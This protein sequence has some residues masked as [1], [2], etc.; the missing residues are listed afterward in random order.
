MPRANPASLHA[1]VRELLRPYMLAGV[2]RVHFAGED[3]P[4]DDG[5]ATPLALLFHELATNAAKY[6]ALSRPDGHIEIASRI[7]GED[8]HLTWQEKGGPAPAPGT[9]GFGS[10]LIALSV[11]GQLRGRFERTFEETGLR[12]DLVVPL[13]SLS[14]RAELRQTPVPPANQTA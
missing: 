4:I 13:A 10:R 7:E 5:A 12:V 14:R 8:C 3:A 9:T 1:L 11:E 2:E 6:G